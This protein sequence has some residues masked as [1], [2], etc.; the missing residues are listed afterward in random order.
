M[1][2]VCLN[3]C[4]ERNFRAE[5]ERTKK[6]DLAMVIVPKSV[7]LPGRT[8]QTAHLLHCQWSKSRHFTF[9][10]TSSLIILLANSSTWKNRKKGQIVCYHAREGVFSIII[11]FGII[12]FLKIYKG[13]MKRGIESFGTDLKHH[14]LNE[15][16][17][18]NQQLRNTQFW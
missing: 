16:S 2:S 17:P 3:M 12:D 10:F 9:T 18:S 5:P 11:F 1:I 4:V 15:E 13:C 6:W 14:Q 8:K 7:G